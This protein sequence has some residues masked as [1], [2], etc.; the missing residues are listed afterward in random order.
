MMLK[1]WAVRFWNN[2]KGLGTL[3]ILLIAGVLIIIAVAFRKQ[4][5]AWVEKVLNQANSDIEMNQDVEIH[6]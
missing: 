5:V 6:E 4:I 2:E 3:E 1:N